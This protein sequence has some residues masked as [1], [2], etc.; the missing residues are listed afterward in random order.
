MG[1]PRWSGTKKKTT[2]SKQSFTGKKQS[3]QRNSDFGSNPV[4]PPF[5]KIPLSNIDLQNWSNY[6]DFKIKGTFS[7]N[8]YIPKNHS[9]CITNLDDYQSTGTH[10]VACAP[11]QNKTLWCFDSFGTHYPKEYENRAIQDSMKVIYNTVPYQHIKSVLWGYYCIYFLHRWS[12]RED[13]YDIL[14]RFSIN[15]TNYNEQIIEKYFK[16]I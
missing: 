5:K 6:L 14:Q 15:D 2:K 9:P 10:W 7:R 3:I 4:K 12:L 16:N 8:T 13:Y 1:E 11:A